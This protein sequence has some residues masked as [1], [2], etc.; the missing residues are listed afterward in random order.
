ML[1]RVVNRF[2]V[3]VFVLVGL[4]WSHSSHAGL[5]W[6]LSDLASSVETHFCIDGAYMDGSGQLQFQKPAP[7]IKLT[8]KGNTVNDGME[9]KYWMIA[10]RNGSDG[11]NQ[12]TLFAG[13]TPQD[14]TAKQT[15]G[16]PAISPFA[17]TKMEGNDKDTKRLL[18]VTFLHNSGKHFIAEECN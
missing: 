6:D 17:A 5:N 13:V 7:N 1:L 18:V 8:F 16:Y 4:L 10:G 2:T 12:P 9:T 3:A 14:M 11:L 15:N